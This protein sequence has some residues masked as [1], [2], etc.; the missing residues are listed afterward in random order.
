M[1]H[2]RVVHINL[3]DAPRGEAEIAWELTQAMGGMGHEAHIFSHQKYT[4][5]TRVTPIPFLQTN[6]QKQA[7]KQ[8]E[9]RG[10]FDLYSAAL[11]QVL[12]NEK[13]EEADLVH[14]HSTSGGY[15]SY[16]LMPFLTVKPTVWTLHEPS[17]FT[18]GC[19]NTNFCSRW[20]DGWCAD[21]QLPEKTGN[22]SV[23]RDAV[24]ILK[25]AIYNVIDV[26]VVCAYKALAG[27]VN[28]SILR[29]KDIRCIYGGVDTATYRPGNRQELRQKLGLPEGK[30]ILLF[31][32]N[33][34]VDSYTKGCNYL[35]EVL[36][37]LNISQPIVLL[38]IGGVD[39]SALK[40][41]KLE[42]IFVPF[43]D[44]PAILSEYYGAA[45][46]FLAPCP[47]ETFNLDMI[48]AM[49]SGI[50]AVGVNLGG[51]CE[52]I[53][54]LQTGY[55]AQ[56]ELPDEFAQGIHL[57][58]ENKEIY[59]LI[60]GNARKRADNMFSRER[61]V[62][63]YCKL[64]EEAVMKAPEYWCSYQK[65]RI[66]EKV[67]TARGGGWDHVWAEFTRIY[68]SMDVCS[69]FSRAG[70][71]DRYLGHC[72]SLV[73]PVN[74]P[75]QFW[76][77][78]ELW[79]SRRKPPPRYAGLEDGEKETILEFS[80]QLRKKLH[81]YIAGTP[82]QE[83]ALLSADR[84]QCIVSIWWQLFFDS[85]SPLNQ[86]SQAS[87]AECCGKE[88]RTAKGD[89]FIRALSAS[90]Y[91][92]FIVDN[93]PF[94]A[95][96]L[97]NTAEL[98]GWIKIILSYWLLNV[99]Y[100]DIETPHRKKVVK[101]LVEITQAPIPPAFFFNFAN[102]LIDY[103][104]R[105]SYTGGNTLRVLS[106]FGDFLTKYMRAFFPNLRYSSAAAMQSTGPRRL[107]V[108]YISRLFRNQAVSYYMVNRLIYH[109]RD[110]FEI[111]IYSLC[112]NNDWMSAIFAQN[113]DK[114]H[115]FGKALHTE[116]IARAI[117]DSDLDILI[118]TD[119]GMDAI[120]Y[121]LAAMQLAPVQ[122]AMVGHGTTT[123]LPTVQY[124]ISGDFE[125]EQA[126]NHYREQLIRLPC[127]G[128]AQ[129]PPPF[130]EG[131]LPERKD[132][133]IPDDVVVFVSCA[134]GIKHQPGRDRLLIDILKRAPNS[135]IVLKPYHILNEE[136]RMTER[137]ETAAAAAGVSER[138]FVIPPL[139]H[140]DA[141]LAIADIQLDT[142]PYGGWTT[143]MEALYS[144]LPIVT[145][146]G[147]MARSRWGAYMLRALGIEEGIAKNEKEYVDWAVKYASD[148]ELRSRV[149]TVIKERVRAVLF[150]GES[151]QAAY[152]EVLLELAKQHG[153]SPW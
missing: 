72:L 73:S 118:Y 33:G 136:Q 57:L 53:E 122:C 113:C 21:C 46:V 150:N 80:L 141:L 60:A 45:D 58:L 115:Y 68:H 2:I 107:R 18:G 119:I 28:A 97:W 30:K 149:K 64:Y 4:S 19:L 116:Q 56:Y 135:C 98:P 71:A 96:E 26:T 70:F 20:R 81:E 10:L 120:T 112:E 43:N 63:E 128:A 52:I 82:V 5:D 125:S 152:E 59:E 92:P 87:V 13:F 83:L 51:N 131:P 100:Y 127:L 103:L 111:H 123:G 143:N 9:Q 101:N 106:G 108:G 130:V 65:E 105:I 15:F 40:K 148:A 62:T 3:F 133:K 25:G 95:K 137:L 153:R 104:W 79:A 36:E 23:Q 77:I 151:A 12:N 78:I 146:E 8:Q 110:K 86:R 39:N 42:K 48:K 76:Q 38:L 140:V 29:N 35:A 102:Q 49:S 145:Q 90:L 16:L 27:K 84:Q 142:Y 37:R 1:K 109:D 44:N 94:S 126:D 75:A 6:W 61:M 85:F 74:E 7:L 132:W 34:D 11:L 129:F 24:Q 138:L 93:L 14:L 22:N 55:L 32:A 89:R 50:P 147:D 31:P 124:Y 47:S 99:P 121:F 54:H 69:S 134:N 117:L 114:F 41:I 67:E 17:A 139:K 66:P 144:G 88:L 91:H